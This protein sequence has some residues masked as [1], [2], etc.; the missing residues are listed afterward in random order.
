MSI[1]CTIAVALAL[2]FEFLQ[3][4]IPFAG[5]FVWPG[6]GAALVTMLPFHTS[7]WDHPKTFEALAVFYNAVL[8]S[9][10]IWGAIALARLARR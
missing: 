9:L 8:Y 2:A 10:V 5:S 1:V 6:M 7:F 3:K 4:W